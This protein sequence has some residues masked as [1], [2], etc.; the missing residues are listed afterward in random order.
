MNRAHLAW[1]FAACAVVA[2]S[3]CDAAEPR[4]LLATTTSVENSGLLAALL[5]PFEHEHAIR[6]DVLPVGSGRAL[7]LLTRGD[8]TAALTHDPPAEAA[9]LDAGAIDGYRKIMFNDFVIVGPPGDPA[10]VAGASGVLEAL[11]RIIDRGAV[12][13][14]R[15]DASGTHSR[16]Q[17]LWAMADRRPP[18]DQL[19]ET[20]QGMAATLRVA[21]E[22]GAYTLTDRST[23][24]QVGPRLRLAVIHQGGPELL[25]SYAIFW[26]AGLSEADRMRAVTLVTWLAEGRGR[27]LIASFPTSARPVFQVWPIGIPYRHPSDRPYAR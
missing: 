10:A 23:F 1:A 22:R 13:A 4:I 14:S 2:A 19:L 6:V 16:E 5:P 15:G 20:G 25:N 24:D 12:F 17:E 18:P 8:V 3:G 7:S 11:H 27:D 21:S 9:A 26:R